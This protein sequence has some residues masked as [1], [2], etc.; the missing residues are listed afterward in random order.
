VLTPSLHGHQCNRE[1]STV[2]SL[3]LR[4][5]RKAVMGAKCHNE[6]IDSASQLLNFSN[7]PAPNKLISAKLWTNNSERERCK[8]TGS[9]REGSE[10]R[11]VEKEDGEEIYEEAR[12]KK[13]G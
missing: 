5:P 10:M 6:L 2:D 4:V 3:S 1:P 12:A 13:T 7:Q 9:E 8:V 11:R